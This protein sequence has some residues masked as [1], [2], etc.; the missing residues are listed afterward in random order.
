MSVRQPSK[1]ATAIAIGAGRTGLGV[2]FLL[3]PEQS[4]RLLGLDSISARRVSWLARM[5]AIRDI[6]LGVGTTVSTVA[7]RDASLWLLGGAV[8]DAVD[9]LAIGEAVR[10]ARLPATKAAPMVVLAAGAAVIGALTALDVHRGG[11]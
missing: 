3:R 8:S 4:T 1:R 7:G 11:H 10:S 6:A 9:A 2:A 5:T